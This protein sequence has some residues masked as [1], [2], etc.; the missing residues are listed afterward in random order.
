MGRHGRQKSGKTAGR[1]SPKQI[2]LC[3]EADVGCLFLVL[4]FCGLYIE[5]KKLERGYEA[6]VYC[7]LGGGMY[8]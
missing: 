8:F 3:S 5:D 1:V 6:V 2:E 4:G 7:L